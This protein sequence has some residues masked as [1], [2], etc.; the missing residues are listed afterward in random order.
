[1]ASRHTEYSDRID[2]KYCAWQ[3]Y[4]LVELGE[5]TPKI[6]KVAYKNFNLPL[7]YRWVIVSVLSFDPNNSPPMPTEVKNALF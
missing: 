7:P 4:D 3:K 6:A 1:M 5:I 2:G